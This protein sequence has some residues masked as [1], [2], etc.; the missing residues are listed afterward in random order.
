MLQ[1]PKTDD[2]LVAALQRL[3]LREGSYIAVADKI[4]ANDQSLYQI[5]QLKP[6]STSKKLKSVGPSLRKR[7]DKEF[8]DWL[9]G[10]VKT[11]EPVT[12]WPGG[13]LEPAWPMQRFPAS[14]WMSLSPAERAIMEEAMLECY[15][16]LMSRRE[17]LRTESSTPRKALKPAA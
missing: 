9:T 7:L 10:V 17:Q 11:R 1:F 6:H 5:A 2:P 13:A 15:D 12:A 4:D 8:P 3:I 16:R 14:Y